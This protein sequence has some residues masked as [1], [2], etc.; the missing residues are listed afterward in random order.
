MCLTCSQEPAGF[1]WM[2]A[3]AGGRPVDWVRISSDSS[4][5]VMY[6]SVS[7]GMT[8]SD[9]PVSYVP[10]THEVS[11]GG[12]GDSSASDWIKTRD[13]ASQR[14]YFASASRGRTVWDEPP[15]WASAAC[16]FISRVLL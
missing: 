9:R 6:H 2:D 10:A 3:D 11:V 15:G 14:V 12:A 16:V 8:V 7:R 13:P 5:R 4:T 1:A